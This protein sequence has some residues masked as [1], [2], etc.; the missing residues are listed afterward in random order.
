MSSQEL[1]KKKERK[2][3]PHCQTQRW[4][5]CSLFLQGWLQLNTAG[6]TEKQ[7]RRGNFCKSRVST[8]QTWSWWGSPAGPLWP[9]RSSGS[10]CRSQASQGTGWFRWATSSGPHMALGTRKMTQFRWRASWKL[11]HDWSYASLPSSIVLPCNSFHALLFL[12]CWK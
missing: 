9:T 10:P 8:C 11:W 2:R 4:A 1:I 12:I 7:P 3:E 5:V 6:T